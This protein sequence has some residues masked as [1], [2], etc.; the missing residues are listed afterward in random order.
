MISANPKNAAKNAK[1]HAPLFA[2]VCLLSSH[3]N[4]LRFYNQIYKNNIFESMLILLDFFFSGK[5]CIEVVP[6]S[7]IAYI[8]EELCIGCGICPKVNFNPYQSTSI[9]N[10]WCRN[11][12]LMQFKSLTCPKI[13]QRTQ[14]TDMDPTPLNYTGMQLPPNVPFFYWGIY[15][16]TRLPTPRP[17]QVLG[18]VGTNGI[19]KST[20]LKVLAG[21]LKPN[22]G[23]YDVCHYTFRHCHM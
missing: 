10:T 14:H 22:L 6:T 5:L 13:C 16:M 18:L 1:N 2:W 21:K 3:W 4:Y 17:G 15:Y 8:S 12:H 11:V 20:A 7:K 23:Q 19:G 9:N